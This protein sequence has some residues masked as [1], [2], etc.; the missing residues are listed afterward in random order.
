MPVRT[1]R[2][3]PA[4]PKGVSYHDGRI[5]RLTKMVFICMAGWL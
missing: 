5:P 4:I 1:A 2:I 3:I